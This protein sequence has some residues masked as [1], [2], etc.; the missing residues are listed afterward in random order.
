M[1]A[2]CMPGACRGQKMALDSMAPELLMT[3][4]HQMGAGN[5]SWVLYKSSKYS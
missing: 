5:K 4:S 3:M 1:C 2:M